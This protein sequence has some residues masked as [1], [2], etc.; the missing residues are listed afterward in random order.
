MKTKDIV[1]ESVKKIPKG[2]V[3]TYGSI[4]KY[5][6]ER[7]K[8]SIPPILVG[9]IL[10]QNP[11]SQ[12]IPCHRVVNRKGKLAENFAFGGAEGQRKKLLAEKVILK[13]K[14]HV[15]LSMCLQIV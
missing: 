15:D 14:N 7:H 6:K 4:S 12:V 11:D 5:L 9:R 2:K 8:I 1:Y 13:D 3:T 10:H